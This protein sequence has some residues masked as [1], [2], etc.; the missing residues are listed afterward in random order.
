[1]N[2]GDSRPHDTI[3]DCERQI[4]KLDDPRWPWLMEAARQ[5]VLANKLQYQG[6]EHAAEI[7]TAIDQD[8][9]S[10]LQSILG[11]AKL[12]R[13]KPDPEQATRPKDDAPNA[14]DLGL[15]DQGQS[16]G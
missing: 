5:S 14:E 9:L 10:F 8:Y 4:E 15:G 7:T 11:A 2:E 3:A 1:M 12:R 16:G 6:V 13:S